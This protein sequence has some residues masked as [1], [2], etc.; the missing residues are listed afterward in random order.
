MLT[1][2]IHY[3]TYQFFKAAE[4]YPLLFVEALI[5]KFKSNRDL[6]EQPNERMVQ[7][8]QDE[9]AYLDDVNYIPPTPANESENPA[10]QEENHNIIDDTMA[11]YLFGAFDRREE[12]SK[13]DRLDKEVETSLEEVDR[14]LLSMGVETH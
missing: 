7:A 10:L 4:G 3:S 8:Q 11:D 1:E 13:D 14:L 9:Q 2:F 5:P 6:W 12:D